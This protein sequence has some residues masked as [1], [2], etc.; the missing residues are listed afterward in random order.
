M[1]IEIAERLHPFSHLPGTRCLLP[2]SNWQLHIF[3]TLVC[4]KDKDELKIILDLVGP[5]K[6]FTVEQDLEKGHVSV[7][8][9]T[10]EGFLRYRLMQSEKAVEIHFEKLPN[11]TMHIDLPSG[12]ILVKENQIQR[13]CASL[14]CALD[15]PPEN[16][17]L[18]MHRSQDWEMVSRRGDLREILPIWF[19]L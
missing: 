2:K 14:P 9:K 19:R 12:K 16:L 18:G 10:A 1:H 3:P 8:G 4:L 15:V 5:V 17:S 11:G 6:N 13:I 7:F